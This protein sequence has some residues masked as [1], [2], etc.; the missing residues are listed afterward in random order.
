MTGGRMQRMS[1]G[2]IWPYDKIVILEFS[3][4]E[5]AAR[6][7]TSPEYTEIAKDRKAGADAK[8]IVVGMTS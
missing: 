1:I 7:R 4:R 5:D 2:G 8:V 6:F 3:T